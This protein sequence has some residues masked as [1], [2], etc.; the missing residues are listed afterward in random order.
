M[1]CP[2]CHAEAA[3]DS[4]FCPHC[5]A[6]LPRMDGG[7]KG[8]PTSAPSD[9]PPGESGAGGAFGGRRRAVTDVP[10]ETLWEGSYSPKAMLGP[11]LGCAAASLALLVFAVAIPHGWRIVPVGLLVLV[12]IALAA[13]LSAKRLGIHYKL[14]N[15]MFYHRRGVFTRT[16][17]RVEAIDIDDV[18]YRQNLFNRM[19][20]V[21]AIK[22]SSSDRTDPELWIEG[23]DDVQEVAQ[24]IDKARRAERLR[25]GVSVEAV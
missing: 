18:A 16:T 12:W 8:K 19:V 2:V 11:V 4:S 13:R 21:G 3:A 5:G 25:R 22:I 20:N 10:E 24:K 9:V 15:Q 17:N 14:T 6:T 23:V 7:G 1:K